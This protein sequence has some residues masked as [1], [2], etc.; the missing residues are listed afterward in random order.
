MNVA[1]YIVQS[2]RR[3]RC[4]AATIGTSSFVTCCSPARKRTVTPSRP[5]CCSGEMRCQSAASGSR[6]MSWAFQVPAHRLLVLAEDRAL[7]HR[8]GEVELLD[9]VGIDRGLRGG[10]PSLR[11]TRTMNDKTIGYSEHT[12]AGR[13]VRG[14][15]APAANYT[16]DASASPSHRR[17][18]RRLRRPPRRV[19]VALV[20]GGGDAGGSAGG[21]PRRPRRRS[22]A[23][24]RRPPPSR[25]PPPARRRRRSRLHRHDGRAPGGAADARADGRHRRLPAARR[26]A[27]L[28]RRI[29][30]P[31]RRRAS[32]TRRAT[33]SRP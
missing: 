8:L 1:R 31:A 25:K 16:I 29:A 15:A 10:H 26:R 19:C 2:K 23:P 13:T 14:T 30:G 12:V 27:A 28:R 11:G 21:A 6:S 20:A 18:R 4:A 33:A 17:R 3:S 22:R 7:E 32:S 24:R 5:F 9:D